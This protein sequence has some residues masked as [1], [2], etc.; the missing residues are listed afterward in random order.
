MWVAHSSRQRI[1]AGKATN[2]DL[3]SVDVCGEVVGRE[4]GQAFHPSVLYWGATRA[5][6]WNHLVSPSGAGPRSRVSSTCLDPAIVNTGSPREERAWGRLGGRVH[7]EGPDG[8][9]RGMP[10][11]LSSLIWGGRAVPSSPVPD[12]FSPGGEA[13]TNTKHR[14]IA[15][16]P[17]A[18]TEGAGIAI[19]CRPSGRGTWGI[20]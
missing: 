16:W 7:G 1:Q 6:C 12:P 18:P 17:Q 9:G 3:L 20:C 8:S 4:L 13:Q 2:L 5:L 11:P 14:S 19:G 10:S 15:G